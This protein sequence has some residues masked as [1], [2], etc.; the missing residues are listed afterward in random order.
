MADVLVKDP[1]GDVGYV[2]ESQLGTL[3]EQG[4]RVLTEEEQAAHASSEQ[5]GT[6]GE[7]LK[8]VGEQALSGATLGL[9]DV[10]LSEALG[11]EYRESRRGRTQ[12][13]GAAADAAHVAGALLPLLVTR[14]AGGGGALGRAGSL[15][16]GV[17]AP[18]RA[19]AGLGRAAESGAG[20][21][22]RGAGV[23]GESIAGRGLLTGTK[24]AAGGAI[25]GGIIGA[26]QGLSEAALAPGGNY[27]HLGQK[28]LSGAKTGAI[29]G[30]L[31][32]GLL[33]FMGGA[34][35]R[36]IQVGAKKLAGKEGLK[37]MLMDQAESATARTVGLR[38]GDARKLG[39]DGWRR[40]S[41][42]LL[43]HTLDD[44]TKLVKIGDDADAIAAK[45]A[46]AREELG[47]K[48]G[49]IRKTV[50][51][52]VLD[53]SALRRQIDDEVIAPLAGSGLPSN[54][55]LARKVA[56]EL[57]GL[58]DVATVGQLTKLRREVDDFIRPGSTKGKI[59]TVKETD[60]A[61]NE[62]ARKMESFVESAV[63]ARVG[64]E[65]ADMYRQLKTRFGA[66]KDAEKIAAREAG[67]EIGRNRFSPFTTGAAIAGAVGTLATGTP[68]G[69]VGGL[70]LGAGRK[71]WQERGE[72]VLA[73]M[74][75]A[76]A[77]SDSGLNASVGQYL[78]RIRAGTRNTIGAG[79]GEEVREQSRIERA[80]RIKKTENRNQAYQRKLK[81]VAAFSPDRIPDWPAFSSA[82]PQAAIA[83]AETMQRARD[84]L[85]QEAPTGLY[86]EGTL[87]PHLKEVKPALAA[88]EKWARKVEAV[89]DPLGTVNRGL[90]N[91][92]LSRDHVRAI[93]HVYPDLFA[94]L[95]QKIFDGVADSKEVVP[96]NERVR[97]GYLFRIPTDKSL[98]PVRFTQLQSLYQQQNPEQPVD[99]QGPASPP[100]AHAQIDRSGPMMTGSQQVATGLGDT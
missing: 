21:L 93:E 45:V 99:A 57:A 95:Q 1:L 59:A 62:A 24:L 4:G 5:Y 91:G 36:A 64:A 69:L 61:L 87:Q 44:G 7:T 66:V 82:A 81:E 94:D 73:R 83:M 78:K 52:D 39:D 74:A 65:T 50:E 16:R 55:K 53:I 70:A 3:I 20:A 10:A 98:N 92:N 30:G 33:G 67:A 32:G 60:E 54:Q 2:D 22:L 86:T 49:N 76:A 56:D 75:Y 71:L 29:F 6:L 13:L 63:E 9:S 14:G 31:S 23:T 58:S 85:A 26:G 68:A 84:Y 97:L 96:Y 25:E 88:L 89:E 18:T 41:R 28:V 19:A 35:T 90:K 79:G 27:E 37:R 38:S 17:G 40:M 48:I 100:P 47:V 77:K 43:E 15:V 34:G 80:L 42:E 11:D 72:S 8:G 51:D 12:E 46:Q